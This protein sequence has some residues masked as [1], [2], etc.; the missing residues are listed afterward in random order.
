MDTELMDINDE[1]LD[2]CVD[3]FINTFS[4]EPWYDVYE[5]RDQVVNYFKHFMEFN[6]FLGFALIVD[7]KVAAISVGMKKPWING[8]EYYIDQFCVDY[9]QQGHGLGSIFLQKIEEQILKLGLKGMMLNTEEGFPS[10]QFYKKN[11][12]QKIDGSVVLVK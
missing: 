10:Y 7:G 9:N 4:K 5:S 8:V 12:F 3:L 2:E 11:G 6:S 1:N